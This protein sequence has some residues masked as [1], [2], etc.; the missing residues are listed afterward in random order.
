MD[1]LLGMPGRNP[2]PPKVAPPFEF[3]WL[4]ITASMVVSSAVHETAGFQDGSEP[5]VTVV[6]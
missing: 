3:A 1:L 4:P 2:P 6:P 5:G